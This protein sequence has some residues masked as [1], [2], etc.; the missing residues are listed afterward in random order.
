L[1]GLYQA[2]TGIKEH[3]QVIIVEGYMDVIALDRLG[4]PIGVAPCG[5]SLTSDHIKLLT[6]HTDNIVTMFDNDSAGQAAGMRSVKLLLEQGI[7]PKIISLP[8]PHKDIDDLANTTDL[9]MD[10]KQAILTSPLDWF[11]AL[12]VQLQ[13]TYPLDHPVAAKQLINE[14]FTILTAIGDYSV[15]V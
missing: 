15:F 4:L 10:D 6:R 7:Y 13:V 14:M 5:T 3:K 2:K 9:T 12:V 8:A 11:D 1:Y